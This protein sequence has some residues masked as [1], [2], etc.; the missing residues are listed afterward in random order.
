MSVEI[1]EDVEEVEVSEIQNNFLPPVISTV[2]RAGKGAFNII[3]ATFWLFVSL[4]LFV[5]DFVAGAFVFAVGV[6]LLISGIVNFKKSNNSLGGFGLSV[7][8]WMHLAAAVLLA[9][10]SQ[11]D[12]FQ[13]TKEVLLQA[14]ELL[15]GLKAFVPEQY[16]EFVNQTF[17]GF[18]IVA[19]C[20]ALGCLCTALSFGSLNRSRRKNLPF[21]KTLFV[22]SAVNLLL[23]LFLVAKG[24]KEVN[25]IIPCRCPIDPKTAWP[26][27]ILLFAFAVVLLLFAVRLFIIYIK[28]RK[29][30]NAVLKA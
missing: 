19:G 13:P 24:L 15:G 1:I 16:G 23:G 29:V 22:S 18:P 4:A 21:T 12:K 25:I 5:W 6:L 9:L 28:M 30:R 8:R 14:S 26:N 17:S 11:F 7:Q 2:R 20:L 3:C 10:V 27:A